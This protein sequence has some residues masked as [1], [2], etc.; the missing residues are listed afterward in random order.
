MGTDGRPGLKSIVDERKKQIPYPAFILGTHPESG[1]DILVRTNK[2]GE[3]FLQKGPAENKKFGNI[4]ED[5][6]PADL[7]VAKALELFD[8]KLAQPESIGDDPVTGRKVAGGTAGSLH[9]WAYR[10]R[11][12]FTIAGDAPADIPAEAEPLIP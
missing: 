10:D 11:P 4:P 3:A 6:A 12:V 9:V 1:E 7:S 2:S 8:K 5:L